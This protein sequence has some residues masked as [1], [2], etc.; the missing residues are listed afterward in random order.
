[1]DLLNL[2]LE[3][4]QAVNKGGER[5]V[6]MVGKRCG[7]ESTSSGWRR[8][9]TVQQLKNKWNNRRGSTLKKVESQK[10]QAG[11]RRCLFSKADD[12]VLEIIGKDNPQVDGV[13]GK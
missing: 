5:R 7:L 11:V 4:K 2:L 9:V 1:M 6:Q 10:R 3:H 8:E 12:I 13:P